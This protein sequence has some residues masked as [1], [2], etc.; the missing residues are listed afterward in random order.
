MCDADTGVI[1]YEWVEGFSDPYPNFNTRHT[2]RN[3]DKLVDWYYDHQVH[4]KKD[5]VTRLEDTV[6]LPVEP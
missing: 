1:T 4:A 6:D 5:G 2:C 3:Y